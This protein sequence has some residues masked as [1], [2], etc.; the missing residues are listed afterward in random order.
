MFDDYSGALSY[1]SHASNTYSLYF[2]YCYT[3]PPPD[4]PW[5]TCAPDSS[6]TRIIESQQEWIEKKSLL[7][8]ML[9]VG[10]KNLF[11]FDAWTWE[12][13]LGFDYT[14]RVFHLCS[15]CIPKSSAKGL[16]SF[17]SGKCGVTC[18]IEDYIFK[19]FN[20]SIDFLASSFLNMWLTFNV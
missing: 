10:G 13:R 16:A 12:Q 6:N 11:L 7:C 1:Y 3:F 14:I 17:S 19:I 15:V 20:Y 18:N 9:C 2:H 4:I 5:G 8:F